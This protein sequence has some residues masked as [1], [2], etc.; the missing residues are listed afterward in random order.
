MD[1]SYYYLNDK[2]VLG[3]FSLEEIFNLKLSGDTLVMNVAENEW[4]PF[5]S[6]I[7]NQEELPNEIWLRLSFYKSPKVN[8]IIFRYSL[9]IFFF[10][11][12][13]ESLIYFCYKYLKESDLQYLANTIDSNIMENNL[14][15]IDGNFEG[16]KYTLP[17]YVTEKKDEKSGNNDVFSSLIDLNQIILKKIDNDSEIKAYSK[18]NTSFFEILK[19]SKTSTGYVMEE[20]TNPLYVGYKQD[21]YY[22]VENIPELGQKGGMY[23]REREEPISCYKSAYDFILKEESKE[24]KWIK[25][26]LHVLKTLQ[27]KVGIIQNDEDIYFSSKYH[28]LSL[29]YRQEI[30]GYGINSIKYVSDGQKNVYYEKKAEYFCIS[31]NESSLIDTILLYASIFAG[32]VILS[33]LIFIIGKH[34]FYRNLH[35][36]GKIWITENGKDAIFFKY[37]IFQKNVLYSV[38]DNQVE[39]YDIE[40]SEKGTVFRVNEKS[41]FNIYKILSLTSNNLKLENSVSKAIFDFTRNNN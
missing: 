32:G 9:L 19:F 35:L 14:S 23:Q 8:T 12:I 13:G 25:G 20:F 36:Y 28:H 3:P 17:N 21:K 26:K 16:N 30:N 33:F 34:N 1:Q 4:K 41:G 11:F 15:V 39:A 29:E 27:P 38:K 18:N 7:K 10:I 31:E 5:S 40:F 22:S 2:Q 37:N 24:S 6:L